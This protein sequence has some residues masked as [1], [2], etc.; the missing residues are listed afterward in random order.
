MATK[1]RKKVVDKWKAKR[2][3]EVV[4]PSMFNSKVIG[5][6]VASDDAVVLDR[7]IEADP[8]ELGALPQE[9]RRRGFARIKVRLR[10]NEINGK[11][12]QTTYIGHA[13]SQS[14]FKTLARRGRSII[15]L[16]EDYQTKD[17]KHIRFKMMSI[18]GSNVSYNTRK[19]LRKA[20]EE[21]LQETIPGMDLE[22]LVMDSLQGKIAGKVYNRLKEITKMM[23]V[24]V[25][26]IELKEKF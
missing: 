12:A 20:M 19:N 26:K 9:R 4:A 2:W 21:V 6:T 18:T 8:S 17:G 25:K 1:K 16:I 13:I 14:Y 10:I 15:D 23:K 22:G 24:E 3:Y 7:I 11:S 5:E